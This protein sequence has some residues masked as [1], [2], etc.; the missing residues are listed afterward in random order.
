MAQSQGYSVKWKNQNASVYNM[1]P[2]FLKENKNINAYMLLLALKHSWE[3]LKAYIKEKIHCIYGSGRS[4]V[5]NMLILFKL[6]YKFN[7]MPN[8]I[9]QGFFL[10]SHKFIIKF[11][12]KWKEPALAKTMLKNNRCGI[13]TLPVFKALL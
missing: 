8:I 11:T 1:S 13:L 9:P 10:K 2:F 5:V 3:K 4:N 12:W 7:T 6:I